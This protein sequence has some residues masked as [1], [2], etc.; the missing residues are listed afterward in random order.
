MTD[1]S[2]KVDR[3]IFFEAEPEQMPALRRAV[4]DWGTRLGVAPQA[5]DP[6]E[7]TTLRRRVAELEAEVGRWRAESESWK[8]AAETMR[9][10]KLCQ[11]CGVRMFNW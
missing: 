6:E 4:A 7:M 5:A 3:I 2:L 11:A 8:Y 9:E 1:G 10:Q